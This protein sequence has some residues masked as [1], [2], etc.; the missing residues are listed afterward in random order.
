MEAI[1]FSGRDILGRGT[2]A[3]NERGDFE[4][5]N[6]V[7]PD[8]DPGI[9]NVVVR[10]GAGDNE[11]SASTT[12]EIKGSGFTGPTMDPIEALSPLGTGLL[13][14]F[15]FNN[16]NKEWTF[17]DTRP[18]LA[19]VNDLSELSTGQVYCLLVDSIQT[20]T[21]NG[22]EHNLTCLGDNCWNQIRW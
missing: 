5:D 21:L 13:R 11:V 9:H 4:V 7:V 8:L 14:V 17:F 6:L 15:Y 3:N 19:E 1:E 22:L 12:F 2:V 20:V 18:E 16:A 10:V